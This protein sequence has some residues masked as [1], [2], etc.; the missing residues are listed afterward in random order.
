MRAVGATFG[1]SPSSQLEM[2]KSLLIKESY[3]FCQIRDEH[4]CET[5]ILNSLR[6][7]ATQQFSEP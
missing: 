3:D 2:S 5:I 6:Y 7:R 4:R 1:H